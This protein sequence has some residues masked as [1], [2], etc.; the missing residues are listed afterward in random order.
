MV[1]CWLSVSTHTAGCTRSRGTRKWR[2]RGDSNPRLSF[3]NNGFQDRRVQPLCHPSTHYLT[4]SLA[5]R[6]PSVANRFSGRVTSVTAVTAV[7]R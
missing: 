1:H 2:R 3:P 4:Y 7:A 6:E 5:S